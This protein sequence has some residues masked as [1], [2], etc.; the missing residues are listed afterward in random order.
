MIANKVFCREAIY[1]TDGSLTG[2]HRQCSHL[3]NAP[4]VCW[5][6]VHWHFGQF[7]WLY[8]QVDKWGFLLKCT[9]LRPSVLLPS[10]LWHCWLGVRKSI[11]PVKNWVM[12]YWRGYLSGVWCKWF[13]WS[14]WCHCHPSSLASVKSR[15]VYLSGAGLPRCPGKKAVKCTYVCM[16][17]CCW[18]RNME[19]VDRHY[20]TLTY[21]INASY[22]D[23]SLA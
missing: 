22:M 14:S 6:Q 4:E 20:H 13:A 3:E 16:Y 21:I 17:V 12:G 9:L 19:Q 7:Q 8:G 1:P 23:C 5:W 15:M 2:A 10:V 18:G 11:R